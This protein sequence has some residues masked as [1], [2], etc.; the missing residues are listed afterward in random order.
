MKTYKNLYPQICAFENLYT[1]FRRARRGGKRGRSEVA[2]FEYHLETELWQLHEELATCTYQPGPYRHF[3]IIERKKRKISA[4]PFRDRVVHHALCQIIQPIFE[5]R[6]IHDSYAC[7]VGKGTH[8]AA[9]LQRATLSHPH[10][11]RPPVAY[12]HTHRHS[13]AAPPAEPPP[14]PPERP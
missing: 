3:Y 10:A 2:A 7:R 13:D 8:R 12:A 14:V 11:H 6:M 1:A 4:A 5:A 9:N